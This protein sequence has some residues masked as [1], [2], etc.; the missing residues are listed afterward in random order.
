MYSRTASVSRL[1]LFYNAFLVTILFFVTKV[2]VFSSVTLSF[3]CVNKDTFCTE[4]FPAPFNVELC[5]FDIP[6]GSLS[7]HQ[8]P[9]FV[10]TLQTDSR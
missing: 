6:I 7:M 3:S 10:A 4:A 8:S 9:L 2:V 1:T 5:K